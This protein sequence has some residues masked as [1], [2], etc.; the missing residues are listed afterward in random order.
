MATEAALATLDHVWGVLQ[1]LGQPL[2]LMGGISL[3]AWNHV[4][5]TRDVELL[6]AADRDQIEPILAALKSHHCLLKTSAQVD[7]VGGAEWH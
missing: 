1:P 3:A 6:I 7:S 5:A 4:R 2:A